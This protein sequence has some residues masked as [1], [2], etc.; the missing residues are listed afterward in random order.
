[1]T[2]EPHPPLQ[3]V[4]A[5]GETPGE[6]W[7]AQRQYVGALLSLRA[8]SAARL[9][10]LVPDTAI[11][12]PLTRWTYELI[13]ALVADHRDPHPVA[14]LHR[15]T[16]QPARQAL[17]PDVAPAS[18]ELHRFTLHLTELY[19]D[20]VV[21]QVIAD[22]A[23]DVLEGAYRAAFHA[24]GTRMQY[25]ADTHTNTTELGVELVEICTELLDLRRRALMCA[26]AR[27]A[28]ALTRSL[29]QVAPQQDPGAFRTLVA[30]RIPP[31]KP[32]C[33]PSIRR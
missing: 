15:A 9:L 22:C 10:A 8:A 16:T 17:H 31:A 2:A 29:K 18:R 25:L 33:G 26:A 23:H 30:P 21:P 28:Q 7:D 1:M 32:S 20:A 6:R 3:I 11:A 4:S 5:V 12:D 14:V 13:R 27:S 19:A 24:A